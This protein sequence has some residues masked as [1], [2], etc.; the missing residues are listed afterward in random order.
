MIDP[1]QASDSWT[2]IDQAFDDL[3][4]KVSAKLETGE[5]VDLAQVAVEHPQYVDRLRKLLPH[6]PGDGSTQMLRLCLAGHLT[7]AS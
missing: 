1:E 2:E 3:V 6:A 7:A 4:C 5:P